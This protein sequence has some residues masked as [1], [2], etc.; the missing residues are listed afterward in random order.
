MVGYVLQVVLCIVV[1]Q[2]ICIL[3]IQYILLIIN[4]ELHELDK[5]V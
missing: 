2:M 3:Y 5:F 4:I 1:L